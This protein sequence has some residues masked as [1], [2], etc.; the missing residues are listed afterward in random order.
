MKTRN[1]FLL[2]LVAFML[3][4]AC[5]DQPY[6]DIPYDANGNVIFTDISEV[7]ATDATVAQPDFTV[8]GYFPNAKAGDVMT[9]EVLK[10]QVP[11][12]DP[13]GATQLLPLA[14][15]EKNITLDGSLTGSVTY[16]KAEAGL[17]NVDDAVTV[18]FSG[19]TDS[20]IIQIRLKP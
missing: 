12:W 6:F 15:T 8:T 13:G 20:G 4:T 11:S 10:A 9:A 17:V 14:G 1:I 3:M 16:T 18:V 19:A 2:T 7:T 5:T